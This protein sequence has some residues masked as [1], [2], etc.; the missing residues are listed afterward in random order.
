MSHGL[1]SQAE[2]DYLYKIHHLQIK[3]EYLSFLEIVLIIWD[4]P[5]TKLE[6]GKMILLLK[7]ISRTIAK[8]S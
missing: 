3:M 5:R 6:L 2:V 8:I 7:K 1:E 4:Q